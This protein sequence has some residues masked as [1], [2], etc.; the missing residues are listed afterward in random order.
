M[1]FTPELRRTLE[2][3]FLPLSCECTLLPEGALMIKIFDPGS[4][5]VVMQVDKLSISH[6]ATVRDVAQLVAELRYDLS[7]CTTPFGSAPGHA[8]L[9]NLFG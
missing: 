9:S 6:L 2:C 3:G 1:L 4:G 8:G 7:T 5:K